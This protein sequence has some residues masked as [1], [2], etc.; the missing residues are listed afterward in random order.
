MEHILHIEAAEGGMLTT[1]PLGTKDG[2]IRC[3]YAEKRLERLAVQGALVLRSHQ[4]E[5]LIIQLIIIIKII[6]FNE[7]LL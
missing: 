2:F 7:L 1:S 4:E 5:G 3:G 6:N